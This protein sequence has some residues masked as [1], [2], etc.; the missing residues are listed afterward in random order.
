MYLEGPTPTAW[1]WRD[2]QP[3]QQ[4]HVPFREFVRQLWVTTEKPRQ[5]WTRRQRREAKGPLVPLDLTRLQ[6]AY[7][8]R[9]SR[10]NARWRMVIKARRCGLSTVEH[11]HM[12]YRCATE[13]AFA[14][15]ALGPTQP[16]TRAIF[17]I[18]RQMAAHLPG[19]RAAATR[20]ELGSGTVEALTAR[21]A[22]VT[23]GLR[24]DKVHVT[25]AAYL[26]R[27]PAQREEARQLL[28]GIQASAQHGEIVLES[29]PYGRNYFYDLWHETE[30]YAK[31]FLPWYKDPWNTLKLGKEEAHELAESMTPEERALGLSPGQAAFRRDVQRRYGPLWRQEYPEDPESCFVS[32]GEGYFD[33]AAL[34]PLLEALEPGLKAH[35]E[36]GHPA[37]G[38]RYVVGVDAASGHGRD[39][40]CAALLGVHAGQME[41]VG[42]IHTKAPP[43][44]FA[45][46]VAALARRYEAEVVVEREAYGLLVLKLLEE[47][48]LRRELYRHPDG[49]EGFPTTAVSRPQLLARLEEAVRIGS[50][51]IRHHTFVLECLDFRLQPSGRWEA[52]HD[53][54]VFAWALA[55]ERGSQPQYR[56]QG[57]KW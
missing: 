33:P 28:A 11:A 16:A 22:T 13:P 51:K 9:I 20:I 21:S 49:R 48:G 26:C 15:Y 54:T 7:S 39:R 8:T 27:G 29:T 1:I 37:R 10:K 17:G 57:V 31:I 14:G 3:Q 25:E 40:S 19:A 2:Y 24:A 35:E 4:E 42:W 52:E 50:L 6:R 56:P 44:V 32:V 46:R 45:A 53:D 34:V 47:L 18:A 36:P 23:R 38:W 43:D 55:L 41:Q 5:Q 12:L 30:N